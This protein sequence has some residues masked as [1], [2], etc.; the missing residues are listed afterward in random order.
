MGSLGAIQY[1]GTG[2]LSLAKL[3]RSIIAATSL[4]HREESLPR[5]LRRWS[6]CAFGDWGASDWTCQAD[7]PKP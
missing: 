4:R 3:A 6:L 2:G 7:D 5:N 1:A